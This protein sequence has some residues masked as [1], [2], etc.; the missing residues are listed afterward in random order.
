M[1][2]IAYLSDEQISRFTSDF[3]VVADYFAHRR[4]DREYRPTNPK[5]F[6]H[7]NE[8]LKLLTAIAHDHRFEEMINPK[9]GTP[10]DMCELLDR[11][12]QKGIAIGEQRGIIIGEQRGIGTKAKA[13]ALAIRE[14]LHVTDAALVAKIVN[15]ET[16][17]VE[18]WF[19]E[20]RQ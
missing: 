14:M 17:L 20:A 18:R 3:Q 15:V 12:E 13:D 9:G 16:E 8:V 7:A 10:N 11:V 4:V 6:D 19:E 2:E 1:F 5:R